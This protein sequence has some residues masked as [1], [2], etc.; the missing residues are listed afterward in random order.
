MKSINTEKI[1]NKD[2]EEIYTK[3]LEYANRIKILV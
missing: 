2:L 3:C 1:T